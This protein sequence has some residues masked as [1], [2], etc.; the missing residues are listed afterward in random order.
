MCFLILISS[1]SLSPYISPELLFNRVKFG[2]GEIARLE[3]KRFGQ[4]I[5]R[6]ELI[7]VIWTWVGN[8]EEHGS[9][10]WIIS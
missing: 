4:K 1:G 10:S 9:N 7:R 3:Q 5:E 2:G 6:V 8:R